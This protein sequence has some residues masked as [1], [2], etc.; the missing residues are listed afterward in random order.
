MA[1]KENIKEK[2]KQGKKQDSK[3]EKEVKKEQKKEESFETLV[4]VFGYDIPGSK[5]IYAGLT[6]IKGISWSLSNAVCTMLKMSRS[7]KI[8]ELSK[9]EIQKIEEFLSRLPVPDYMKNRRKDYETGETK[10]YFGTALEM[11]KEFD[12]KRLKEIKSYKGIRHA[13]KLPLR[14][15][16]TRSHFRTKSAA[17]TMKA[18]KKA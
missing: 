2:G 5:N 14:G 11:K 1:D 13:A 16:R 10:H 4:R 17:S 12:I 18:R 3:A 7:K 15:Q 6:Y 9:S 8:S